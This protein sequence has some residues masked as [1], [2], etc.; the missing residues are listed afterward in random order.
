MD[1]ISITTSFIAGILGIA[2]PI[3]LEVISRLDEK[4]N[5]LI[6]LDLFRMEKKM[7][8]FTRTLI[9]CLVALLL[10]ILNFPPP[11][12]EYTLGVDLESSA[13]WLV[14]VL[15]VVLIVTFFSFINI[16]LTYYTPTRFFRYLEK[17]H[18]ANPA[19]NNYEY[20]QAISDILYY[21]IRKQNEKIALSVADFIYRA[22]MTIRDDQRPDAVTYPRQY[23][24]MVYRTIEELADNK[25]HRLRFLE[26]RSASGVWIMGESGGKLSE[27]SYGW[28]WHNLRLGLKYEKDDFILFHW[29]QAYQYKQRELGHIRLEHGDPPDFAVLNQKEIDERNEERNRFLEF[30]YMLGALLLSQHRYKSLKR[31]FSFTQSIPPQYELLPQTMDEVFKWYFEFADP[32]DMKHPDLE[33]KYSFPELSGLEAGDTIRGQFAEYMALLFLR[34]YTL[35]SYLYGMEPLAKPSLPGKQYEKKRW[36]ENLPYFKKSLTKILENT[37]L[38]EALGYDVIT[39]EWCRLNRKPTPLELVD[40][41]IESVSESFERAQAYQPVSKTKYE[42]FI[43]SSKEIIEPVLKQYD[44]LQNP[45]SIEGD[46]EKRFVHGV[47]YVMDKSAF[48]DD[49]EADHLNYDS[50]VA[51]SFVTKFTGAIHEIFVVGSSRRYLF[52]QQDIGEAVRKLNIKANEYS[53]FAFG[54]DRNAIVSLLNNSGIHSANVIELPSADGRLGT[55]LFVVRNTDLPHLLFKE[56]DEDNQRKFGLVKI[57]TQYNVY[58][59]VADLHEMTELR[60]SLEATERDKDLHKYVYAA[61]AIRLEMRWKKRSAWIEFGVASPFRRQGVINKLADIQAITENDNNTTN[62]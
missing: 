5:S 18:A 48:A 40:Q 51:Q 47:Y 61:I 55:S 62:T 7:K 53:F 12:K 37:A 33:Y 6:I 43:A 21:S 32:Y 57:L 20:F 56:T 25:N 54:L 35:H 41:I 9:A 3:L 60:Q 44:P 11:S 38:L 10:H 52:E 23:Y 39:E 49:Q 42:K 4:Y 16:V 28:L 46:F 13:K 22:F 15:T 1:A 59:T 8:L 26:H 14:V 36:M 19:K 45:D 31:A 34:Q 27:A 2:Y 24:D 50:I 58:A 30:H 29:E 17:K